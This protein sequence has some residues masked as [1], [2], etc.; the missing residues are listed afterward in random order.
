VYAEIRRQL[1]SDSKEAQ[2]LHELFGTG[3][4]IHGMVLPRLR[5]RL[6][7]RYQGRG[8]QGRV[9]GPNEFERNADLRLKY[10][11]NEL[12][13]QQWRSQLQR[14]EKQREHA[15]ALVQ[16]HEMYCTASDEIFASMAAGQRQALEALRELQQ[17]HEY[18]EES[19]QAIA[20]RFNMKALK[21]NRQ[22]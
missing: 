8:L 4:H 2:Q 16:V 6:Q 9:E 17:L 11:L 13:D 3:S 7:G 15:V 21:L 18:G 14:R 19:L 10:L 5:R 22:S 12:D 20:R 1:G